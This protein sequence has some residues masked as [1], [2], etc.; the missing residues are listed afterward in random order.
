MPICRM[1]STAKKIRYG[2]GWRFTSDYL[3]YSFSFSNSS[4]VWRYFDL[5]FLHQALKFAKYQLIILLI[6]GLLL[7]GWYKEST[8][9]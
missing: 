5:P 2:F 3:C 6:L 4:I 8:L 9:A 7:N 1:L